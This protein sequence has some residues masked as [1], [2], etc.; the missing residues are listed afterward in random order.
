[1]VQQCSFLL[2]EVEMWLSSCHAIAIVCSKRRS[3]DIMEVAD[4]LQQLPALS[5]DQA[6]AAEAC[7]R[8][9][10]LGPVESISGG[11][12]Q[13]QHLIAKRYNLA[14]DIGGAFAGS[15]VPPLLS[16]RK[17]HGGFPGVWCVAGSAAPS[18]GTAVPGQQ[19]AGSLHMSPSKLAASYHHHQQQQQQQQAGVFS[20]Q[21][22]QC[23][24]DP[25]SSSHHGHHAHHY[26]HHM[27]L[28]SRSHDGDCGAGPAPH[29]L[30]AGP[31][32]L[33]DAKSLAAGLEMQQQQPSSTEGM[34]DTSDNATACKELSQ[35]MM[36]VFSGREGPSS[37]G[38]SNH[39]PR[40]SSLCILLQLRHRCL[41]PPGRTL[42]A[43]AVSLPCC[44]SLSLRRWG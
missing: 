12:E 42:C 31:A 36:D 13:R 41:V 11:L 37:R 8:A 26:G 1:M 19:L 29:Q 43:P 18:A 30:R 14:G 16:Q 4:Q 6:A 2:A 34:M 32:A 17:Q 3:L 39:I 35:D 24:Q 20:R 25:S 7:N 10:E 38:S 28:G 23:C 5:S 27:R 33:R 40:L 44:R 21:V 22:Q 9:P 15:L